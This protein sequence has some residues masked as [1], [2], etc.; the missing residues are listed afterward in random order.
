MATTN[1]DLNALGI[2]VAIIAQTSILSVFLGRLSQRVQ[3]MK[4]DLCDMKQTG[5]QA[6]T[7]QLTH[8]SLERR[9]AANEKLIAAMRG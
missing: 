9:V 6:S 3:D 7:C 8:A 1:L 4:E 5:V 2:I